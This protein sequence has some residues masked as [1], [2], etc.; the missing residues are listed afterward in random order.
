[1]GYFKKKKILITGGSG[2]IASHLCR[3]LVKYGARVFI[4]TKYK[5][6]IDNIR[7]TDIWDKITPVEADLRNPDALKKINIYKPELIYHFAAYNHVGDSF[8]NISEAIDVNSKGTVN[9]LDAYE[10]YEKFVYIS[11]SEVYGFQKRVPFS[12]DMKPFPISPYAV[13]KYTGELYARMKWH[14]YKKPI[15]ILRPF[16]VFGPFQSPRAVIAEIILKCLRGNDLITTGG[17][18]TREFNYVE[19][20]IDGF[21][22]AGIKKQATGE[23]INIGT[24]REISIR[25][26]AEKIHKLTN[27]KSRLCIGKISYRPTE[28][29]RMAAENKKAKKILGWSPKV[30]FEEGLFRTIEWYRKFNHLF[31]DSN[32]PLRQLCNEGD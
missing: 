4:L 26:L 6:I 5:S 12:E 21:I 29:W 16:N 24:G 11:S 3:R 28:I 23:V 32:S 13:G 18:Q 2:F 17:M 7:L 20:L 30:S 9:L 25:F 31:F 10:D 8:G 1:M 22:L 27:S 15:V 14:V 19:N